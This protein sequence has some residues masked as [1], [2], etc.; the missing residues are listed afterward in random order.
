MSEGDTVTDWLLV[1]PGSLDRN[2]DDE[3]YPEANPKYGLWDYEITNNEGDPSPRVQLAPGDTELIN[4]DITLTDRVAEGNHTIYLRIREDISDLSAARYFD[5]SLIIQIGKDDPLLTIH[6]ISQSH[7]L[8]PGEISEIQMKVKNSGNSDV[9]VLL[10][11]D[12][13]FGGTASVVSQNGAQVVTIPAF[14][15]VS[16]TVTIKANDDSQKG[17]EMRISV[18]AKPLSEE[19]S[20]PDASTAKKEVNIMITIEDFGE[21]IKNELMNPRPVTIFIGLGIIILLVAAITGR[22]NR[23]EYI[24]VWVDE[25]EFEE[26]TQMELPDTVSAEDDDFY[27]DDEIEL[28]DFD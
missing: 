16:F 28:I 20:F 5:L 15:E 17:D 25:D 27:D 23:V 18:S 4:L 26:E 21:L 3:L 12:V 2:I 14:S 6:Q 19:E 9:L 22:R 11:A 7:A 8:K 13:E 10:D 1:D 24:D